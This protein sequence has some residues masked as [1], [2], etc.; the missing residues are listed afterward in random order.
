MPYCPK[1]GKE[2]KENENLCAQCAAAE[3]NTSFEETVKEKF[4]EIN[5]TADTTA[6]YDTADINNN[7]VFAILA[8][9]GIL[10]LVP[11]FAA[12]ESR[13]ARFHA[14][15]GLVLFIFYIAWNIIYSIVNGVLKLIPFVGVFFWLLGWLVNIVFLAFMIIGIVNAAQGK[16]KELPLVGSVKILK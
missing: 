4:N 12:K 13:F 10:V 15:Q 6:E 7:K 9:I 2:I 1:C 8:Y 3:N 14:N 5:N 16:A 11:V